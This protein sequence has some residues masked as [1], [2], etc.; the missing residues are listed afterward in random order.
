MTVERVRVGDV[1]RLERTQV[2]PDASTEYVAIGVRSFGKGL[3]HYEPTSGGQL[4]KLRFFRVNP[5]R[6]VVSNIKAW[7]GAVAVSTA[8]DNG[9]I[10]S[11][12]FLTYAPV[13]R[14][15]DVRW[16]R[17]YFLSDA[18][19]E[20]LQQASPGS[21][22]RNR[23]LSIGRFETLQIPLPPIEQQSQVANRLGEIHRASADIRRRSERASELGDAL[24]VSLASRPD[25]TDSEKLAAGWRRVRLDSVMQP[26]A[27]RVAVAPD[28]TYPNLGVY[29]FGR[30]LFAKPDIDGA[31]TSANV[32]YRV[33]AGQFI[34]SR[35]F[36]FEGAYAYV[37]A[38]LDGYYV[39]NEFPAFDTD[40]DRLDA[41]WLA[42]VL[43]SSERWN[44][45]RGRSK[46][47]GV[48]RQRV[49]V[50]AVMDYEVWLP[51]LATQHGVIDVVVQLQKAQKAR[52][53]AK[54]RLG[55]LLP[56]SLNEAF[57]GL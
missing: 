33:R 2:D 35:L 32:L 53:S 7:E 46:G 13:D 23:T 50:E 25:L 34:Y 48:R 18:G 38:S 40:P 24:A 14:K 16:A 27:A 29:S 3:F 39:S 6:L 57:A 11:S 49:P 21:A 45:L 10:A 55:A 43:R 5:G 51:P 17:W 9:C 12:R 20:Q 15:V 4:G 47:L 1:L 28:R 52:D 19:N 36:A 37:P 56:S 8:A 26:S 22:D 44:E 54:Q 30:G 41:R 42:T 31:K